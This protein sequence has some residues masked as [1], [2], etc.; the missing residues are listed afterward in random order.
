MVKHPPPLAW[1]SSFAHS[2]GGALDCSVTM[3]SEPTINPLIHKV[4]ADF[5]EPISGRRMMLVWNLFQKYA[6]RNDCITE[7]GVEGW[8]K[9]MTMKVGTKRRLGHPKDQHPLD[10]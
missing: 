4:K 9:Q 2:L 6:A 8:G 10:K 1:L 3:S 5:G 7:G